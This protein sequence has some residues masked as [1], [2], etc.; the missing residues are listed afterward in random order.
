MH[1]DRLDQCSL[2]VR[3]IL[4]DYVWR[5]F[6]WREL[7]VL[8]RKWRFVIMNILKWFYCKQFEAP[9]VFKL[10]N[11]RKH[12][13]LIYVHQCQLLFTQKCSSTRTVFMEFFLNCF[14]AF[15]CFLSIFEKIPYLESGET[16]TN[17]VTVWKSIYHFRYCRSARYLFT[18][19][20]FIYLFGDCRIL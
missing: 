20:E 19:A 15:F 4:E 18:I 10:A 14:S 9:K 8:R 16:E 11:S 3:R 7:V 12:S 5:I 13:I 6:A 1:F 2:N 17:L